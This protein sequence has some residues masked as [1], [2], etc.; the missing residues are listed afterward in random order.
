[1]TVNKRAVSGWWDDYKELDLK[2]G[3][4]NFIIE[5]D[6]D[7]IE[8]FYDD[9]MLIDIGKPT[10]CDSYCITVVSSNDAD[11]W[12]NPIAQIDVNYKKDLVSKIQEII[13][14]FR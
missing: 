2:G 1:M 8:I 7:M 13:D 6:E 12:N 11:G 3:R 5:D 9:G 4:I 14:K 10:A